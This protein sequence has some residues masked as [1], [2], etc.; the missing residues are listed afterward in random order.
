MFFLVY[1][2]Y[3]FIV[4]IYIYMAEVFKRW[5]NKTEVDGVVPLLQ[6]PQPT[7]DYLEWLVTGLHKDT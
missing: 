4:Y 6:T 2:Y 5:C 7:Q 3:V 1:T